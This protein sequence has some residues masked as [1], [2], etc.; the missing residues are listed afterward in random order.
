MYGGPKIGD[1]IDWSEEESSWSMV[2]KEDT[3]ERQHQDPPSQSTEEE[4][5]EM[6]VAEVWSWLG[7][8]LGMAGKLPS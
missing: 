6:V 7:S 5:D 3:T 4:A 1:L 2:K 8:Y